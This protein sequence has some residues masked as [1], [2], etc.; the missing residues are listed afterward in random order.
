MLR[1]LSMTEAQE[2]EIVTFIFLSFSL[3]THEIIIHAAEFQ[4]E[5]DYIH[6]EVED[7]LTGKLDAYLRR[8]AKE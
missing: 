4:N 6:L 8:T 5:A 7:N 3:M 2:T 1:K